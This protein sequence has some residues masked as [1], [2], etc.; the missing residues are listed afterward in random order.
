LKKTLKKLHLIDQLNTEL[1]ISKEDF[2][3]LLMLNI[4]EGSL[5]AFTGLFEIFS[6]SKNEFK[7]QVSTNGFK[8]RKKRK[9]FQVNMILAVAEG[10]FKQEDEKLII[11][12]EINGFS[13]HMKFFYAFLLFFY[14]IFT[15]VWILI[16]DQDQSDIG[17]FILPFIFIHGLLMLGIPYFLMRKNV[18][19]L[20]HDLERAF[21]FWTKE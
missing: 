21:Y 12:A 8:L 2:V 6:S 5:S 1:K 7:G 18:R 9:L 19:M 4:D 11:N 14:L 13:G 17:L 16:P 3:N 10:T 15:V 20:K